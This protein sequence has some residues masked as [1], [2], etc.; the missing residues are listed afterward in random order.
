MSTVEPG[1]ILD[2]CWQMSY[3]WK[4]SEVMTLSVGLDKC[5][6]ANGIKSELFASKVWRKD[7]NQTFLIHRMNIFSFF[8]VKHIC[9]FLPAN[10]CKFASAKK[11]DFPEIQWM[12]E[13]DELDW[14]WRVP[15]C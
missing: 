14:K 9:Q 4:L 12:N 2:T 15:K 1:G 5:K 11:I 10:K 13:I 7:N 8:K 6:L 3:K